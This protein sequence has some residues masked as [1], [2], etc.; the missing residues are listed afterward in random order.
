MEILIRHSAKGQPT[1]MELR[2]EIKAS[3]II[4]NVSLE[5]ESADDTFEV[6]IDG[7]IVYRKQGPEYP[8]P[9]HVLDNIVHYDLGRR[10]TGF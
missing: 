10:K 3:T 7:N 8:H 1:A 5:E 9:M 6:L 2:N 4:E